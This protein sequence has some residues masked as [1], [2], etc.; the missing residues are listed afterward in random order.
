MHEKRQ[1]ISLSDSYVYSGILTENDLLPTYQAI[2]SYSPGRHALP[3][4]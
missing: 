1:E 4:V 2:D 3:R